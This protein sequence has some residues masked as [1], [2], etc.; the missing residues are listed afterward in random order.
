MCTSSVSG[1]LYHSEIRLQNKKTGATRVV[2]PGPTSGRCALDKAF[3][4]A[5]G[6]A[7]KAAD[8]TSKDSALARAVGLRNG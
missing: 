3:H 8:G 5:F 7:S 6:K 2:I 4:G 1:A